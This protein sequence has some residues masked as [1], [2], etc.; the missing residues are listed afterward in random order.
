M[1]LTYMYP[2]II[3]IIYSPM[4]NIILVKNVITEALKHCRTIEGFTY[5]T[6]FLI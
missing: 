6:Y 4:Y 2:N 5:K 1:K 3:S